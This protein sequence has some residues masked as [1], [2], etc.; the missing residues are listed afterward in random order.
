M[1]LLLLDS[2][3]VS[4]V[5]KHKRFIST[6]LRE[7]CQSLCPENSAFSGSNLVSVWCGADPERERCPSSATAEMSLPLLFMIYVKSQKSMVSVSA[8]CSQHS[9]SSCVAA[10]TGALLLLAGCPLRARGLVTLT[11]SHVNVGSAMLSMHTC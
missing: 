8:D 4:Q 11:N 7:F 6:F 5:L 10:M 1:W 9:M 2:G 3:D